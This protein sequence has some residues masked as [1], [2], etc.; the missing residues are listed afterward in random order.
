MGDFYA[1]L[2]ECGG[3]SVNQDSITLQRMVTRKGTVS[4]A[5]LCDGMG[6]MDRGEIASGY[7]AERIGIWFYDVLPKVLK[8]GYRAGAVSK[9]LQ[10]CLFRIH[11]DLREY[12]EERGMRCG[13]TFT[14]LLIVEK[15]WQLFHLG[16][17][18]AYRLGR[19]AKRITYPHTGKGGLVH[20]IGIGRYHKPQE[21]RGRWNN[22]GS[23][24]LT[25]DGL[26]H[27]L[28]EQDL[29]H[30]LNRER[31]GNRAQ[32][33]KALRGLAKAAIRRGERDNM[34]AVYL[35]CGK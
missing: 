28:K 17:S 4:L 15:R 31:I 13:T 10:R 5:L 22:T 29:Y 16:D 20:C 23:F 8:G 1:V 9:A 18:S 21:R 7:V 19:C 32:A 2:H 24:L 34:S 35:R 11:E 3:R 6:G 26:Q 12:G 33:E 14:L 30:A 27:Y 25:S